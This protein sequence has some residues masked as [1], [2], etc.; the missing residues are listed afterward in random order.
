[1][2]SNMNSHIG[3]NSQG[4]RNSRNVLNSH[5]GRNSRDKAIT[6][7]S[8]LGS[9]AASA[10]GMTLVL[11]G[12]SPASEASSSSSSSSSASASSSSGASSTA[13]SASAS[14]GAKSPEPIAGAGDL[15][16]VLVAYFSASGNTRAVAENI[17]SDL[18][19]DI[20]EITPE[21]LYTSED[22]NWQADG[23][24]VNAEHNDEALRDVELQQ[25]T[26]DNFGEYDTIILG[27]PIWWA[28]AAWPVDGFVSGNDFTGKTVIPFCTSTSSGI[29]SSADLLE[30]L[31]GSGTWLDGHR[32]SSRPTEEEVASWV[33]TL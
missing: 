27:Y 32:F 31:A 1:M 11:A 26:P 2:M 16:K 23:S 21:V 25:V 8:F 4:S 9:V 29:G 19:A 33:D 30:E 28:I 14:A 7:R 24:R 13:S 20:F 12:C 3:R 6:R 5:I 10:F 22:L 15:G 17:A 18:D